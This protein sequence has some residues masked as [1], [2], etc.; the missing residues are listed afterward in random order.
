MNALPPPRSLKDQ[1]AFLPT[2]STTAAVIAVLDNITEMMAENE[3]ILII[4]MNYTKAFDSIHHDAVSE[5]LLC[6]DMPDAIYNWFVEY[7]VDRRHY[8]SFEGCT[9]TVAT[10]NANVVQGSVIGPQSLSSP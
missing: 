7:L 4:S 10:I 1:F 5:V 2:E 6:L 9:F 8:T 3:Y